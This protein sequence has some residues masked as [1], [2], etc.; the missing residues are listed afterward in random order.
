MTWCQQLIKWPVSL[1]PVAYF[2]KK[3]NP[4]LAKLPLKFNGVLAKLGLASFVFKPLHGV[5]SIISIVLSPT[6]L[7]LNTSI[8]AK[9]IT[10]KCGVH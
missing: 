1:S 8:C 2:T 10:T 9:T 6:Y 7:V 5:I 3:V 4:S